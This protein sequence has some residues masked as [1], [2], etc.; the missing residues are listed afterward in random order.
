MLIVAL[1]LSALNAIMGCARSLHQMS[2]RRPVPALLPAHQPPRRAG[3]RDGLQRGLL[4]AGRPARRRGRDLLVLERR[5]YR[6]ADHR[7]DRLL[8]AAPL[9][10]ERPAARPAARAV[11]VRRARR[12]RL[13]VRL[14]VLRRDLL[15]PHRQHRDLLLPRLGRRGALP[16][17]V[18]LPDARGGQEVRHAGADP[19][20]AVGG[21]P[22]AELDAAD[23][24]SRAGCAARARGAAS[25]GRPAGLRGARA[26]LGGRRDGGAARG[27]VR[28]TRLRVRDRA[29]PRHQPRLPEPG[30]AAHQAGVGRAAQERR[31]GGQGAAQARG[32][33]GG[34]RRRHAV[35]GQE[36][37]PGGGAPGLRRHRDGRRPAAQRLGVA[38]SSGPR[39]PS[40]YASAPG[41]RSTW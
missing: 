20:D 2:R 14:L 40:A 32:A 16:P 27:P 11:Q 35:G 12:R 19:A 9:P 4:A 39:S 29:R 26:L 17:A 15:R 34:A 38:T 23:R 3:Q 1:M 31:E 13:P 18:P 8:P 24:R 25:A 22:I 21:G 28:C 33:G 5:L 7:P 37:R 30:A 41:C 36:D 10:A 6:L